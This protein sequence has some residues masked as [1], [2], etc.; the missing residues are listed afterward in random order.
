MLD[1]ASSKRMAH[2]DK[3]DI[4]PM[5]QEKVVLPPKVSR[6]YCPIQDG[7]PADGALRDR[8]LKMAAKLVGERKPVPP[9][10]LAELR[11]MAEAIRC[12]A[13]V[14][15]VYTD[16]VALLVSNETWRE[17]ISGIPYSQRL[18]LLPKC[19]RDSRRCQGMIDEFGLICARCG[20]CVIHDLTQEAERLGYSVLIAEGTAVVTAMIESKQLEAVIGVSCLGVLEKCFPHME[21]MSIP[22]MA[23]P[24]LY[25]GCIDT[26]TD[27]EWVL[28]AIHLSSQSRIPRIDL[29]KTRDAVRHWFFPESLAAV[30]GPPTDETA[31]LAQ[32][33]LARDGKRWRPVLA[34]CTAL[35]LSDSQLLLPPNNDL[36]LRKLAVSVECFHKASLIHD[37]IEDDDNL[38]YGEQTMHTQHGV[39]LAL[40]T[41][42]YLLGEGYRLIS[43]LDIPHQRKCEMLSIA[44]NGHVTLSRGQGAE[45]C[46]M[47]NGKP[48][49]TREVLSIFKNKTSPAFE[50]AL[51]LGAALR[52]ASAD[53]HQLLS[54]Y[55]DSLGIAYQIHDDLV[56]YSDASGGGDLRQ[57]RLSVV[58]SIAYHRAKTNDARQLLDAVYNGRISFEHVETNVLELIRDANVL[59]TATDLRESYMAQ[60]IRSLRPLENQALKGLLRRVI[61][62]IFGENLAEGYCRELEKRDVASGE[63]RTDSVG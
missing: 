45:L 18:L 6:Q 11:E 46:W 28:D 10:S 25:D 22:G 14:D 20:A 42:D 31:L 27:L 29:S 35:A 32:E 58:L 21:A 39:P 8:L 56:D 52:G 9:L 7:I 49:G 33:W 13:K 23:I 43:E 15:S 37:D 55:S 19:L 44:A 50:V 63:P 48:L 30:M 51:R 40:N 61:G 26:R 36:N 41:G 2:V 47:R 17:T 59:E 53:V 16:Y 57:L 24:L 3:T 60:A 54:K 34:V 62:R 12:E 4:Q 5:E 38:R 1:R